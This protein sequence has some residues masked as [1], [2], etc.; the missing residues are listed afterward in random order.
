[1]MKWIGSGAA[2]ILT[3]AP[4]FAQVPSERDSER[5][6]PPSDKIQSPGD[7]PSSNSATL[8]GEDQEFIRKAAMIN[9]IAMTEGQ[10]AQHQ[11]QSDK[12]RTFGD[13]MASDHA[14]VGQALEQ[15]A[16]TKG[17]PVP[18]SPDRENGKE[19]DRLRSSHGDG[20]D[21]VFTTDAVKND[22]AVVEM[23]RKA[24]KSSDPDVALVARNS[25]PVLQSRL[26]S[27]RELK[28]GITK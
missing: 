16:Q 13:Q 15:L 10:I 23:F 20:F 18:I 19:I 12:V 11:G 4:A 27:A 17:V 6:N 26:A 9:K 8:N 5:M 3:I 28:D 7:R 1:M 22:E 2:L 14:R 21:R 25:L 24:S